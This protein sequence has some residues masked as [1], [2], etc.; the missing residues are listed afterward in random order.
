M[1]ICGKCKLQKEFSFFH[2]ATREKDGYQTWCKQCRSGWK[3][4]DKR[5]KDKN[6]YHSNKD[7]YRNDWYLRTYGITLEQY[8]IMLA[9]QN[10]VCA[11][12]KKECTS[13]RK[14]AVDHCHTTNHVRG[15]LCINCNRGLGYFKDSSSLLLDAQN[16]LEKKYA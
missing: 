9:K 13:G 6:R 2:K 5:L 7:G 10:N 14:L 4:E 15:L 16:Y 11:I 1:K 3:V 8:N 12:C